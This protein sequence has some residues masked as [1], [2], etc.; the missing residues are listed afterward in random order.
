MHVARGS[1]LLLVAAGCVVPSFGTDLSLT[2]DGET[3]LPDDT[4]VVDTEPAPDTDETED[5]DTFGFPDDTDETEDTD[6]PGPGTALNCHPF[7]PVSYSGWQRKYRVSFP[8]LGCNLATGRNCGVETHVPEGL[9]DLPMK[10]GGQT[11][12][13]FKVKQ[14]VAQAGN[15]NYTQ[16]VWSKC[17]PTG[18]E[19]GIYE[20]GYNYTVGSETLK[21]VLKQANNPHRYLP[22]EAKFYAGFDPSWQVTDL[23]YTI[24]VPA[25]N[26]I[27]QQL[28]C[29]QTATG[30]RKVTATYVG[31][32][33]ESLTVADV[34]VTDA[35]KLNVILE[36][37]QQ[38]TGRDGGFQCQ[39]IGDLYGPLFDAFGAAFGFLGFDASTGGFV[40]ASIDRW[41]VRGVGLVKEV[42]VDYLSRADLYSKELS[43]CSGLPDC[44]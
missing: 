18:L 27:T 5:D 17:D 2:D 44:P 1:W 28:G 36:Q 35:Y 3:D 20:Y 24:Q 34:G 40:T 15:N 43:S 9:L 38:I 30:F 41:Y 33:F 6:T 4:E 8:G 19:R 14:T 32:G 26:P 13:G 39:L 21:A 7:D 37:E 31:L 25:R 23:R 16:S 12:Q 10:I 11:L 42:G 29:P 22:D